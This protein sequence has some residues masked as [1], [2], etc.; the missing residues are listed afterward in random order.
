M[1]Q[2][3]DLIEPVIGFR[4]WRLT[5]RGLTSPYIPLPWSR[6][7]MEARCYWS[8]LLAKQDRVK[9]AHLAPHPTCR[10]GIYAD[11]E[12]KPRPPLPY[13]WSVFGIVTVWGRIELHREGMRAQHARVEALAL[14]AEWALRQ[15][16]GIE[17]AAA[18]LGVDLVDY[19]SLGERAEDYGRH[20]PAFLIPGWSAP[21]TPSDAA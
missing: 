8:P 3:P 20:L 18:D 12:P 15:R 19:R 9:G 21:A 2:A 6:P 7:V 13:V 5:S 1:T 14:S 4:K 16:R 17:R 11:Y 10:C